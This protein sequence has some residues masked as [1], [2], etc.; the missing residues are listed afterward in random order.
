MVFQLRKRLSVF[1][2]LLLSLELDKILLIVLKS[3]DYWRSPTAFAKFSF[4][5]GE[6][7]TEHW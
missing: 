4:C 2:L 1:Y 5:H 6:R 7:I 3:Q